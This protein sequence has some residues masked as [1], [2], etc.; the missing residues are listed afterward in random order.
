MNDIAFLKARLPLVP[1]TWKSWLGKMLSLFDVHVLL[2]L[3]YVNSGRKRD[4]ESVGRGRER[5]REDGRGERERLFVYF[6]NH[7]VLNVRCLHMVS[8]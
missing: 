4:S 3:M 7:S 5:G 6:V 1:R 2:C 8:A